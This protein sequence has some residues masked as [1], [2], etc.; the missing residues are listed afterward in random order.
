MN[1]PKASSR[2]WNERSSAS[3]SP[4]ADTGAMFQLLFERSADAMSLFDPESGRFVES[5]EAVARHVG[6]P[7]KEALGNVS[8]AEIS[9]ERQPD[10]RLSSE[11]AAE[12]V[13]LALTQG[14]HRFHK[15]LGRNPFAA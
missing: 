4:L 7:S 13:R 6:A 5:N 11:K 10:G 8:V 15:S 1:T 9:P 3:G 12:M 14:S 2:Q